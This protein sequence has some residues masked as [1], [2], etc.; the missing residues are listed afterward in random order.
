MKKF[1]YVL[2]AALL[3]TFCVLAA[4]TEGIDTENTKMLTYPAISKA[5]IAFVYAEDL[6]V[7]DRNGDNVRRLTSDEG[8]E[9]NPVFS[10]DGNFIAFNAQYDGNTDVFIVPA[11]GGIPKRLTWHPY[12]DYVCD[13]TPD[14][15]AVLFRSGRT[16][17]TN[18]YSQLYTVS[19][20]GGFPNKLKIPRAYK[21]DYS[22]DGEKIA[23]TPLYEA[24][25]QWKQYR[26]GTIST[27]NIF[28]FKDYSVEKI[29]QPEGGCNDTDPMWIGDKIYFRS[30][31]N[32]EFNLFSYDTNSKEIEQLTRFDDFP[33]LNASACRGNIIFERAGRLSTFD[34]K[35]GK[36]EKLIIGIAADLPELRRRYEKGFNYIRDVSI[37]PSGARAVLDF[38]GD[39]VTVPEEK[40]DPRNLTQTTAVHECYPAWSPDG[41]FIAYFSDESG[42]Y[43]LHIQPQD[44]KGGVEKIAL[45]GAGFYNAIHWSPDSKKLTFADNGRSLYLVDIES[46]KI[47]KIAQDPIYEPG[48]FGSIEGVWSHDSKWIA[49]T[50][51]TTS[52]MNRVHVYSVEQNKSYAITDGMSDVSEPV[53]DKSGKYLY[54]FASTDAGPVRHWFAM[55]NADMEMNRNIYLVTLKEETASPLA[56]ESDEVEPA[57]EEEENKDK[58]KEKKD[59]DTSVSIDFE[60]LNNRIISLPVNAG[61]YLQLQTGEEGQIFYMEQ[62]GTDFRNIQRKLHKYD[63]NKRK[64]TVLSSDV[65]WYELSADNKKLIYRT[66]NSLHIVNASG[67]IKP[68]TGKLKTSDIEVYIDPKEE[69]FQIFDEAWRINRDYFYDPNMHGADW[70]A[71][72][73]KYEV[74][75]PHCSCRSDLNRVIQ[76]MCSELSV[77][78]HRVFGG[79][80]PDS[81][82]RIPGGLLGA[83]YIIKNGKYQFEKVYGGLNWN[84]SLRSPL[85]EPGIDVKKGESLLAVNGKKLNPP[86][87]L[88]KHFENKSGKIVEITVGP[89][90]S[91]KGSRTLKVVP[92]S[93]ESSLRN[94]DWVEGNIKKVNE[95][96]DGRV[97]YVYVPN[98]STLGHTYFKRYFFPQTHKDAIIIDERF[99]GGG[100][101]ADY[102]IDHLRRP[103]I[104]YW[105]MRYGKDLVT[106]SAAIFGPKVMI[107]NETAGSGG[108]LLPWMFRKLKMGKLIGKRTWGGL[109]G[110]LGFPTLMDGG[111][112]TAPNLAIWTEDGFVVENVGVPPDIEVEQTP[113][114]VIAG[115]DPQLEKAIEVVMEEL[116]KN[117]PKKPE[118]PPYPVRVRK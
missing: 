87:N 71:M 28:T 80:K 13:F 12:S 48:A 69:W 17:F 93:N 49:Y 118:R 21:A 36:S 91:G 109:V 73:K 115:H 95:A 90:P 57:Q 42:E 88:Y 4:G 2:F 27:I 79:D 112:I 37:S 50:L 104:C 39:I 6:W 20:E 10:P 11:K 81:P 82:E 33:I 14:G 8:I 26:G 96:T 92:I 94:R 24:F 47:T 55:S 84:P 54:F 85:K 40:G 44:G 15:S 38:R 116:K 78:H 89:D 77:G 45:N 117:P 22:P 68:G 72:K 58:A 29:P 114:K 34:I 83:D 25:N 32:G 53:F 31:R 1:S 99:N 107:I 65:R 5:K 18:R 41:K 70:D 98:T 106:P 100:S 60:G 97:A 23:Y 16:S 35:T 75:L 105:N 56:K 111:Y 61:L 62:I 101:V 67:K 113:A 108:D 7:A 46:G 102:Y 74:F 76:W 51:T 86:D 59:E 52:Y 30:D 3:L 110:I 43:A 63:L 64:D 19:A 9:S 66:R 103:F